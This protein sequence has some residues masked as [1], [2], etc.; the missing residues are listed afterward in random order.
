M[1]DRTVVIVGAKRTPIG[2]FQGQFSDCS[3]V[4]LG[5]AAIAGAVK[6][7][8]IDPADASEVIMGC[9]LPGAMGQAPARQAMLKAGIPSSTGAMTINKV[10]GSGLKAIALGAD[11]CVI[12]TADIVAVEC[13]RCS[14]CESGR[15]CARGIASTDPELGYMTTEEY[16]E[17]RIVNMYMAWRKQW[18]EILRSFGMKS[19]KEL[20]GRSDLL[21]HLD[22]LEEDERSKYQPAPHS[23]PLTFDSLQ[24]GEKFVVGKTSFRFLELQ[25]PVWVEKL[26]GTV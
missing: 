3:G 6:Q 1:T 8:G 15:G 22:Y 11:G 17:Q 16:V 23:G 12:G 4:D 2:S 19:I 7:A 14:N 10:C 25:A 26:A 24:A 18:C 21:V 20:R 13:V 5:A 9:V